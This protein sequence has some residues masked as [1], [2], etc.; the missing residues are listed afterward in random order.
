M[1]YFH[2]MGGRIHHLTA[3]RA[4]EAAARRSSFQMAAEELDISPSAISHQIRTL[5]S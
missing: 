4:F 2:L 3:L 5:E 1:K